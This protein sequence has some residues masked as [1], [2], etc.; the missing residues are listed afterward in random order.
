MKKI[1]TILFLMTIGLKNPY[2]VFAFLYVFVGIGGIIFA[3]VMLQNS[4]V[5]LFW[6]LVIVLCCTTVSSIF[7]Y[8]FISSDT[9]HTIKKG[10]ND[11]D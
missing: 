8:V 4:L 10:R 3:T 6:G 11:D 9:Y 1:K 5:I 7:L 2:G